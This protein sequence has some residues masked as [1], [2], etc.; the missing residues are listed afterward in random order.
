MSTLTRVPGQL[1]LLAAAALIVLSVQYARPC[2]AHGADAAVAIVRGLDA[3]RAEHGAP[4]LRSPAH[5]RVMLSRGIR[6]VGIGIAHG[7][8]GK[9]P[10]GGGRTYTADFGS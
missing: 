1:P 9:G 6:V 2:S 10:A 5:R 8:P 4:P 7:T 3:A